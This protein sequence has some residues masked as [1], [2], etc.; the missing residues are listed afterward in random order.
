[1]GVVEDCGSGD[2]NTG[3]SGGCVLPLT[4]GWARREINGTIGAT[5]LV[6]STETIIES[7]DIKVN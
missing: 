3:A 5:F 1:M 7:A 6:M 2:D 4:S